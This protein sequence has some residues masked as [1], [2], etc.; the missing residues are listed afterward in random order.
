VIDIN[1]L[2]VGDVMSDAPVC[3]DVATDFATAYSTLVGEGV[4]GAPIVAA[5]EVVGVVSILDLLLSL[6]PVLDPQGDA[7]LADVDSTRRATLAELTGTVATCGRSTV[8]TEACKRMVRERVHRLVVI[9]EGA[10]VG[11]VSAID[12][13]RALAAWSEQESEG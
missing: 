11:V 10:V 7:D 1:D 3:L 2:R 13:V 9:E 8:L 6:A 12:V 4:Q 5:G